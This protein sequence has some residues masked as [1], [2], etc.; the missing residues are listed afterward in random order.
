MQLPEMHSS[1]CAQPDKH[2]RYLLGVWNPMR[3]CLEIAASD[4]GELIGHVF[5][6]PRKLQGA[7][8]T[9]NSFIPSFIYLLQF[10]PNVKP[11]R[12]KRGGYHVFLSS[13]PAAREICIFEFFTSCRP[14]WISQHIRWLFK[15]MYIDD[16]L[17]FFCALVYYIHILCPMHIVNMIPSPYYIF[18]RRMVCLSPYCM[19]SWP[20][21]K[22]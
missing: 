19:E 21:I 6:G 18:P 3:V 9:S 2:V 10:P 17:F 14:C 11:E 5:F 22:A 1:E 15:P 16:V 12:R 13:K 20:N 8:N 7:I 4:G